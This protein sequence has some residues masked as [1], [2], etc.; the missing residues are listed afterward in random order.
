M[1]QAAAGENRDGASPPPAGRQLWL[2][3][4]P[5]ERLVGAVVEAA[6]RS[7]MRATRTF[8]VPNALS[9]LVWAGARLRA[10]LGR[11][12]RLVDGLCLRVTSGQWTG[13]L[14]EITDVQP[15][16]RWLTPALVELGLW[17]ASYYAAS[18][19]K[20]FTAI[21]P[22]A[23]RKRVERQITYVRAAA[24]PPEAR[25]TSRQR[26]LLEVLGA[27]PLPRRDALRRSGAS[28]AVLRRLI[29]AGLVEILHETVEA[30]AAGEIADSDLARDDPADAFALT[31]GQEHAI[32]R[33]AAQ[34]DAAER[35]RV[36]LLFGVP[37][38]G[39]TEV[40]VR[41]I[42]AAAARGEQAIL[43]IPEIAL[44]TQLVERLRRRFSRVAVLH[45]RLSPRARAAALERIAAGDVDV[46]IGT[47]SAVFAPVPR[48]GVLIV[49]EEQEPSFKNLASPYYHARDVAIMRGS[50]ERAVVMLGSG[51][52][53]LETW[54]NA[55]ARPHYE[56][57]RLPERVP[58]AELPAV[59]H[60]IHRSVERLLSEP[61]LTRIDEVLGA[62]GQCVLLHNRRGF[63]IALKC[64]RCGLVPRCDRCERTMVLH[65]RARELR[66]HAC[67]ARRPA[68]ETCEDRTCGGALRSGAGGIQRLEQELAE[69]RPG[70]RLLR[71]DS[72][73]VRRPAEYAAALDAF[74]R[75]EADVLIGTQMV[76]KGLDFPGVRLVGVIDV[77]AAL[78]LPDFRSGERVF[79]LIV[80]VIGRAGRRGGESL[81]MIQT[82]NSP[83]PVV[84]HALAM[85][86]EAFAADELRHRRRLGYPPY[87]F[88]V[89]VVV[90]DELAARARRTAESVAEA[91]RRVAGSVDAG[92]EVSAPTRSA[93]GRKR[94]RWRFEMLLRCERRA[95]LHALLERVESDRALRRAGG[96]VVDVDPV[97][98]M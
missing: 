32:T 64:E 66:C 45:S 40:Y 26:A 62:G 85:D 84:R 52:P 21:V 42:R 19:W 31:A 69:R 18:P 96:V 38:S 28:A 50:I 70:L 13:T 59:R 74:E 93:V 87:A 14:R 54:V 48:L 12:G 80:Q 79:Q 1:G 15:G 49:D 77:D 86:Y 4:E 81:A 2:L 37:G 20:A 88:L 53:S 23:S 98:L 5:G 71:L 25:V 82:A 76:A 73:A 94:G 11:R 43:L 8:A 97:D 47:R 78:A 6:L 39:K 83:S 92:L 7:P 27:G 61:L 34:L 29:A 10:P 90:S 55:A 68:P 17:L 46:V 9:E 36:F 67:G 44:T 3:P 63:S 75:G 58:G 24:A 41:V 65:L 91:L 57:L 30:T 56:L 16:V 51:T 95:A 89:R 35:F 72:D 22:V 60:V 33:A